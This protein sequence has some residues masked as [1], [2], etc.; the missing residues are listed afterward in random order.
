M[1]DAFKLWPEPESERP[2]APAH[3]H[4]PIQQLER[5]LC[6]ELG[7]R[8]VPLLSEPAVNGRVCLSCGR[9]SR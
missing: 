3:V 5:V 1:I 7:H 2:K 8:W 4:M 6:A 9:W